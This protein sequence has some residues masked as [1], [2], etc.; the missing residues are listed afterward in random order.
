MQPEA[1]SPHE[2]YIFEA[3]EDVT[4][5]SNISLVVGVWKRTTGQ[6]RQDEAIGGRKKQPQHNLNS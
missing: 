2:D 5:R 3:Y 1:R 4:N 6:V